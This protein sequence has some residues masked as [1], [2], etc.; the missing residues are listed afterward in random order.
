VQDPRAPLVALCLILLCS[1]VARVIDL[2]LPCTKPC[3]TPA[4][5][6]LIFDEA[7]YV[8]AA[9]VID[10]INPPAGA[11]YHD[12][13]RGKDPNAEHPQLA[14]LVIAGTIKLFGDNPG[15]WRSGSV[16]FALLAFLALYALVRAAGGSRWLAV[17]A[18]AVMASDNLLLVHGRIATLDIYGVAMMLVAGTFYL[19]RRPAFAGVALAVGACMKEVALYL[20]VV[21]FLLE[22]LRFTRER[23]GP[24]AEA[25]ASDPAAHSAT[26]PGM[27]TN[28]RP[29]AICALWTLGGFVGLIWLLDVLVPAYDPVAHVTYAGNPFSHLSHIYHYALALKSRPDAV[30]IAASPW[31]WL[32]N[33]NTIDYA[34]VAVNKA[35]DGHLVS[36]RA[37]VYFRGSINPF[38]IFLAIP[39][40]FAACAAAWRERDGVSSIGACWCLGTFVPF[41]FESQ[42]SGRINYLYYMVV[43]MPGLYLVCARLFSRREM[44]TA[45]LLGWAVALIYGF[46]HL[47]PIRTLL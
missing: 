22:V 4:S 5:H 35:T 40:T 20:L 27:G 23:W 30:G 42:T 28:I 1:L 19:R 32:L 13:P 39:A 45:A 34:R 14:K 2:R 25:G 29:L 21:L 6:T 18:T 10:G 46:V 43:V 11:P 15:G 12:A 3:R 31:Q 26:P 47:Y 33:E 16:L 41:A 38:I 17:G 37:I 36:S 7:Y 9:R 44:P 24:R 8:N